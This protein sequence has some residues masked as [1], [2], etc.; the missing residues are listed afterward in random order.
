MAF[1]CCPNQ[2]S[3]TTLLFL[4]FLRMDLGREKK[5]K[6]QQAY[7]ATNRLRMTLR[8]PVFLIELNNES[9]I[10]LRSYPVPIG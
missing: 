1:V 4:N 5:K 3:L 7:L 2:N 9:V 6:S 8:H 10:T